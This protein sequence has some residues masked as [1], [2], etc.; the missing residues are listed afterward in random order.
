MLQVA[1][2]VRPGL[3]RIQPYVPGL[4]DDEI[5]RMYGVQRVV[6]LNANENALGPSP[7]ALEAIA[8]EANILHLYPD[9]GSG[10]L[11]QAIAEFHGVRQE[12]VLAGNGS[13]DIIK[14][15]AETFLEPDDEV[16]VPTPSF[17][18]YGLGA[19]IMGARQV[20]VPLRAD[21]SYDVEAIYQAVGPKTK[22]VYICS[23][24]NPTGTLFTAEQAEWLLDAL[25]EHVMVVFDLA[26]NDYTENPARV[27]ENPRLL[28]DPR[29]IILH[30]FSKLYGLAGLRVGY[31]LAQP[32]VW[33]FV[34]RVREPFNVNRMAQRA[35]AAA[36]KDEDHR[37]RSREHAEKS[38][39][40]Y[41]FI[42]A[43]L[44]LD[45]VPSEAN[46]VLIRTGDGM[47]TVRSLMSKG[48][49][50]RAGF[51]G[52]EAYIRVTF[53]TDAENQAFHAAMQE[54]LAEKG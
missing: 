18:Q 13:D 19:A 50:V 26:Y 21:F 54:L 41:R 33:E 34:H 17:S 6:K 14:L 40:Y 8:A 31:G 43:D 32:E 24:N 7:K 44:G 12:Q 38:R 42:A 45:M 53:G 15:L 37:R 49:L 20:S 27:R 36:L 39:E 9:G 23:P 22:V 46:F 47:Q 51:P 16:V 48:V 29:V 11:R 25:P 1:D 4:T 30:T 3:D 28:N 52:V 35:A 5:K 2:R 10:W